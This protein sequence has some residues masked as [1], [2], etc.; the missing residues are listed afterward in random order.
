VSNVAVFGASWGKTTF[1]RS[2]ILALAASHPP[3]A[4]HIYLLDFGSLGL[5][6]FEKLPHVGAV[7]SAEESERINRLLRRLIDEKEARKVRFT[8]ASVQDLV[9]YNRRALEDPYDDIDPIPAI[10]VVI[11][12]FAEIKEN[13]DD[14]IPS[15]SELL[16]EGRGVGI[17]FAASADIP[18]SMGSK[19]VNQFG[20]R[21]ALTMSDRGEYM[22]LVG[23]G[24]TA[25]GEI[26]GRGLLNVERDISPVPLEVQ[27]AAPVGLD[28]EQITTAVGSADDPR[29]ELDPAALL[30]ALQGRRKLSKRMRAII[31]AN[32]KRIV[33][34]LTSHLGEQIDKL[35][36]QMD[37]H[38]TGERPQS[39]D[40]LPALLDIPAVL[41]R[42]EAQREDSLGAASA[43]LGMNDDD[44][45]PFAIK[46][47]V[48]YNHLMVIGA[49]LSGRTTVLRTWVLSL[50]QQYRP[51]EVS[52][53]IIDPSQRF[54]QYGGDKFFRDLPHV[55]DYVTQA[56]ELKTLVERLEFEYSERQEGEDHRPPREIFVLMDNYDDIG[57]LADNRSEALKQLARLARTYQTRLHFILCGSPGIIGTGDDLRKQVW[58]SKVGLALRSAEAVEKLNGKMPRSLKD[59]ELPPGRGFLVETGRGKLVQ[60]ATYAAGENAA[61][62]AKA[63][64][65]V[66]SR[67]KDDADNQRHQWYYDLRGQGQ[68]T[69]SDTPAP[70]VSSSPAPQ[71]NGPAPQAN[72]QPPR[73]NT[74]QSQG[75]GEAL[76]KARQERIQRNKSHPYYE[77]LLSAENI[78]KLG[79]D[80]LQGLAFDFGNQGSAADIIKQ[81]VFVLR[82]WIDEGLIV[83]PDSLSAE[84]EA[85]ARAAIQAH[86]EAERRRQEEARKERIL[87]PEEEAKARERIAKQNRQSSVYEL[88]S[89]K[90]LKA[91][92]TEVLLLIPTFKDEETRAL[93]G[94]SSAE[95]LQAMIDNGRL[96]LPMALKDEVMQA[97]RPYATPS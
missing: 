18:G 71:A 70:Q 21:L 4:L 55:L 1:L 58:Q 41:A 20:R 12:N 67:L 14:L 56:E 96:R 65:L 92:P 19:I 94:D 46:F 30:Q 73:P 22:T 72:G 57:D 63:L 78:R 91:L 39:V 53:V 87:S 60:I 69:A 29:Q 5:K 10:L 36:K 97:V 3:S 13:Y 44:L 52:F 83:L 85:Q 32:E 64:D 38:W 35:V 17:Y 51:H 80:I 76:R 33:D 50:A 89:G 95:E 25:F 16:R 28:E 11:D 81:P 86:D 6:V 24:G 8:K 90:T 23:R 26:Y 31:V 9:S 45:A 42:P 84:Q 68:E 74:A 62:Y 49:P 40:I 93:I 77:T 7:I 15:F 27:V 37:A 79:L 66:I 54:D 75:V 48:R 43:F 59:V 34:H 61:A 2:L 88:L 47:G 82:N